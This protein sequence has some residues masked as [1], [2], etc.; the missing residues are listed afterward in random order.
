MISKSDER[1][2]ARARQI[3]LQSDY[4]REHVGCIV[5]YQGKIVELVVIQRKHIQYSIITTN[6]ETTTGMNILFQNF[7]QKST[8]LIVSVIWILISKK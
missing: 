6:I 4:H 3:A 8:A 5:V 1:L 7:T 2:F